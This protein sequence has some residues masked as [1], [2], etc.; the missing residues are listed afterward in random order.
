MDYYQNVVGE[1][2]RA[3]RSMFIN[4]EFF[5]SLDEGK[6]I[7]G[8]TWYIDLLVADF[9][10][11]RLLLCEVSYEKALS[12][13]HERLR[14]WSMHWTEIE[15]AI[16]RDSKMPNDWSVRPWLFLPEAQL[17][18]FLAKLTYFPVKPLITPLEMTVPWSFCTWDRLSEGP[19]PSIIPADM[20][21]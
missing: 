19:K 21:T 6:E 2:L 13:L 12:K 10:M 14:N 16:K 15:K 17:G 11:K 1:Y 20:Q 8:R 5:L 3:N 18:K 7:K 4:P 9:A